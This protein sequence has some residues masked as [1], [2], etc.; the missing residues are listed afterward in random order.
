[1]LKEHLMMESKRS[2][3]VLKDARPTKQTM[4]VE[5]PPYPATWVFDNLAFIG[6]E[7]VSC[8]ILDTS[9]GLILIDAM[10]PTDHYLDLIEKSIADL[11]L[12]GKDLKAVLI[13]H[14]HDD[15]FGRADALREKY[16][17]KIYMS[18]TDYKIARERPEKPF[19]L[20]FE[21]D[22][23]IEDGSD[24]TLGD[25]TVHS[26]LTPGHTAGCMSFIFPVLDEGRLHYLAIWGGTG[27]LPNSDKQAYLDS[28]DKFDKVCDK[29]NV[30]CEISNHPFVDN[31]IERMEVIRKIKKATPNPFVIGREAY[32]RYEDFFRGMA[33]AAIERDK[34]AGK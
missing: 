26:V 32:K 17:C 28:V 21:V 12:D 20:K 2:W 7:K 25:T 33:L 24:F 15:H 1:M 6:D 30:D 11:G 27:V 13:T 31:S 4:E 9:D 3:R 19:G 8:F 29:Y 16:G 14:G 10:F 34:A 23:F 22:G 5:V 18:E